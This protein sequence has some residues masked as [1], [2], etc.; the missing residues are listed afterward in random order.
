LNGECSIPAFTIQHSFFLN[1]ECCLRECCSLVRPAPH[2]HARLN[3]K[4]SI[5]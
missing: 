3:R 4:S 2:T 5:A 1:V